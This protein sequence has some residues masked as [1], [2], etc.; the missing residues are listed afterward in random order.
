MTILKVAGPWFDDQEIPERT[1]TDP[2][3]SYMLTWKWVRVEKSKK[4]VKVSG[5][6]DQGADVTLEAEMLLVAVGRMPSIENL[7]RE[8]IKVIVNSRGTIKVNDY[9]ETDESDVY[10]IGDV[11]DIAWLAHVA[12]TEGSM[13][14][15]KIEGKKVEPINLRLVPN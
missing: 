9:C 2:P 1:F 11:I 8:N 4:G 5:K 13:V 12:S 15:E 14:V 3:D 6:T 7:G 10:A